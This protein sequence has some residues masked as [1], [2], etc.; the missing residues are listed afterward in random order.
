M[1]FAEGQQVLVKR[2]QQTGT[3]DR[4]LAYLADMY[5]VALHGQNTPK[6]KLAHESDLEPLIQNGRLSA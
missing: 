5:V 3:I 6:K 1:A 4:K 2:G